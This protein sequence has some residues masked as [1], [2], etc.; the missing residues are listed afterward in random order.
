MRF[1][2]YGAERR[3]AVE[4]ALRNQFNQLWNANYFH[5]RTVKKDRLI[6][7]KKLGLRLKFDC[8]QRKT[9]RETVIEKT[10][11]EAGMQ[12]DWSDENP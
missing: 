6:R 3:A 11:T 2:C 10:L 5:C 9:K 12:I 8:V 4:T 1:K 7:E